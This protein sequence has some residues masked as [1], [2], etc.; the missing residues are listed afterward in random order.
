MHP[1]DEAVVVFKHVAKPATSAPP[2]LPANNLDPDS[3]NAY[4]KTALAGST[5]NKRVTAQVDSHVSMASANAP[6]GATLA[7]HVTSNSS[8]KQA[9][10]ASISAPAE[11]VAT[12]HAASPKGPLVPHA[13][14]AMYV[15]LDFDASR[16]RSAV[17]QSASNH[18]QGARPAKMAVP[19]SQG[20][21]SA[22]ARVTASAPMVPNAIRSFRDLQELVV[23]PHP[24]P[25]PQEKN[26]TVPPVK[27]AIVSAKAPGHKALEK[28]ATL[29]KDAK[30]A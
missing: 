21:I 11:A 1:T 26:A 30:M 14:K 7:S 24:N 12:S 25:A 19:V 20:S 16:T 4:P 23:P 10:N 28:P 18:V 15:T 8:A 5:A 27:P 22:H 3:S 6:E 2:A 9:S 13:K 29:S 17:A